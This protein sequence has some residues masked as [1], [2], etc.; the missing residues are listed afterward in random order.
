MDVLSLHGWSDYFFQRGQ[1]E[2]WADRGARFF[3]L[4]LRKYGRSLHPGQ[5]PGY[6]E[7]LTDYH[8]EISA[9]LEIIRSSQ[10]SPRR[11]L[12]LGHSTGGLVASLWAADH[13]GQVDALVLNSPWLEFQLASTGRAALS[14][15][16]TLSARYYPRDAGPQIDEGFYA[17]AQQQV[18]PAD[19]L[20]LANP[21]WRPERAFRPTAGWLRAILAGHARIYQGLHL[22]EPVVVLLSARSAVPT[23]WREGF[24]YADTVLDVDEVA[25]S[26]LHLG[27]TVTVVRIDGALHDV[28]LSATEPRANAFSQLERW[29]SGWHFSHYLAPA[30]V[31]ASPRT[32]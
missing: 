14:P 26:A 7:D 21:V 15:L 19:D 11:L 17:R 25:R 9:A 4:D 2:F 20:A 22:T 24:Q 13:P 1:A 3:A 31:T 30:P 8:Q 32:G 16:I 5:T 29:V 23:T 10:R 28:F 18:G 6:I 27:S 12:L